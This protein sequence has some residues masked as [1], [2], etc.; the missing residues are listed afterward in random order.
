[1]F[2]QQADKLQGERKIAYLM[3]I[4]KDKL[5]Y[6]KTKP[7]SLKVQSNSAM[8]P[9]K[10]LNIGKHARVNSGKHR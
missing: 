7:I 3:T 5:C 9:L 2:S 6:A 4:L 8:Y 10:I 1:M